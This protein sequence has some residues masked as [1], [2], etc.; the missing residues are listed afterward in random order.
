MDLERERDKEKECV[1]AYVCVCARAHSLS[2]Q[3]RLFIFCS[4][5]VGI[6]CS[7]LSDAYPLPRVCVCVYTFSPIASPCCC[8]YKSIVVK[9]VG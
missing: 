8:F 2:L 3:G 7:L 1:R 4:K 9:G 6:L 5:V